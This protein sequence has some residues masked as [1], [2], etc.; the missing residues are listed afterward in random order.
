MSD[1]WAVGRDTS[2]G[3]GVSSSDARLAMGGLGHPL[4][5]GSTF[6][7]G[8]GIFPSI[9]ANGTITDCQVQA[10]TPTPNM[11]AQVN[12]G[13]YQIA[14]SYQGIYL[15]ALKSPV[16]IAFAP[17]NASNPRIDYV[18]IRIRD[19]DVDTPAPART[20]D[21]IVFTG[22][23]AATPTEPLAQLT[24]GDFV[25]AAVTIRAATTQVLTGDIVDRRVYAVARGGIYPM[26]A[27]D[28]RVGGYPGQ[29]R[30]NVATKTY[31]GWEPVSG[32]WVPF[33][34]L[35]TWVS[36]SP[37]LYY[38]AGGAVDLTKICNLGTGAITSARYNLVGKRLTLNYFFQW[39]AAPYNMGYGT[40]YTTLPAGMYASQQTHLHTELYVAPDS[41]RWDGN[42]L[43]NSGENI[44]YPQFPY[45]YQDNRL[46]WYQCS[47]SS[48]RYSGTGTPR[49]VND[50][51]QA[52]TLSMAGTVE[53]S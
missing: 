7:N 2:Q 22:T 21:V 33:G 39:G 8:S 6:G 18:V 23:P 14:R 42:C 27:A 30:Y 49:I 40:V 16:P 3:N 24:D 31:E 26:S 20:A 19:A 43:I 52:G 44:M 50:Y 37:Q 4:P 45:H 15:G 5:G 11:G 53:I 32:A 34:S 36:F 29:M 46:S 25:L 35:T 13:N 48:N 51:P 38:L 10:S 47:S 17:A 41:S 28:T 1:P 12:F 9:T